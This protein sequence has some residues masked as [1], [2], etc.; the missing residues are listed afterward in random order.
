M[1]K[2]YVSTKTPEQEKIRRLEDEL[3]SARLIII[4][5]MPERQ[6]QILESYRDCGTRTDTYCWGN[7]IAEELIATAEFIPAHFGGRAYCPPVTG[8]QLV[9]LLAVAPGVKSTAQFSA[10]E[11]YNHKLAA[12][13]IDGCSMQSWG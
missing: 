3:F 7:K 2:L 4:G 10:R 6:R 8:Q 5:L 11:Q 1:S 12:T 13:Y 9:E